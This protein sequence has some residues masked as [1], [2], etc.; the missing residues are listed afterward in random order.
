MT[1]RQGAHEPPCSPGPRGG[2]GPWGRTSSL[3]A[4][5]TREG[6][7]MIVDEAAVVRGAHAG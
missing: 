6:Q 1:E 4:C 5:L 3:G 2:L 7:T